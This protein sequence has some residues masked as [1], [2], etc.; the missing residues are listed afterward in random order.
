M[1]AK[2]NFVWHD[3]MAADVESAKKFYGELFGWT[4]DH[5]DK[6]P[7]EHISASGQAIGGIVTLK[8][9]AGV[10][11]HWI[12]YVSTDDVD[13]TLALIGKNGGK[14]LVPKTSIPEVGQFAVAADPAG[15]SFSPFFYSGPGAGQ[16]ES[17]APAAQYTFCWDELVSNDP[18]KV[19][20]FYAAV[21]GWGV[22]KL[23]MGT[24]GGYTL[25]KRTGVKDA[26]GADKNAGG[27]MKG[28]PG[29][30]ASFWIPYVAVPD[31]DATAAKVTRL[32]GKILAPPMDIPNVGRFAACLD[33]QNAA[34]SVLQPAK[35]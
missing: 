35:E 15:A 10:P 29:T 5:G 1:G 3:L 6:D 25:F 13:A 2:S 19:A 23:D 31:A 12:G 14:V 11:S 26:M 28:P 33:P 18:D 8:A 20:P 24:Y 7:Y 30:P 16:P 4:F 17:N 32:G 34:F 21:F 27:L 9:A 22:E